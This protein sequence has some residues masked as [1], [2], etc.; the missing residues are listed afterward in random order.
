MSNEEGGIRSPYLRLER[1]DQ[2]RAWP[3]SMRYISH[4][5]SSAAGIWRTYPGF[6]FT[7]WTIC[8]N[9]AGCTGTLGRS[10]KIG[11]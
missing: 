2:E 8:E 3:A 10:G 4:Q 11:P 1:R 6:S 9:K 5:T 7:A